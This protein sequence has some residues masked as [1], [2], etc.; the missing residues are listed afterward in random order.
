VLEKRLVLGWGV[1]RD[2]DIYYLRKD[3]NGGGVDNWRKKEALAIKLPI[4]PSTCIKKAPF[5]YPS[6]L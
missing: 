4:K 6:I 2:R 1:Y 3:H 5:I